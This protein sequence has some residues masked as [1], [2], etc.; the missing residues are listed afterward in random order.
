VSF[1][2]KL[3][4]TVFGYFDTLTNFWWILAV[5]AGM[6][7]I[8]FV[9][10]HWMFLAIIPTTLITIALLLFLCPDHR[11]NL[12]DGLRDVFHAN[13]YRSFV[14]EVKEWDVRL[15]FFAFLSFFFTFVGMIA[16]FFIPISAY[17]GGASLS[18]IALLGVISAL[19]EL[20]GSQLGKL[21]DKLKEKS[22]FFG[23]LLICAM[24]VLL[25]FTNAYLWYLF[26]AFGIGVALEL[27]GLAGT[28]IC[29]RLSKRDQYGRVNS[30]M[31]GINELGSL[32]GPIVLGLMIDAIMIQ[33]T[34]LVLAAITLILLIFVQ[35]KHILS[36]S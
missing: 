7:I 36:K 21:S 30:A 6:V 23:G 1:S 25:F 16:E 5:F 2:Q 11:K 4:A 34:A 35:S 17:V 33:G 19:P 28:G 31:Q 24:L 12:R 22:V 26:I 3:I 15:K 32:A 14:S 18:Q 10:L 9:P 8:K 29:T 13:F 20:C 27:I